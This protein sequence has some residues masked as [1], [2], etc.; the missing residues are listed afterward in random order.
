MGSWVRRKFDFAF[1]SFN[2]NA[3][4]GESLSGGSWG[5]SQRAS[6]PLNRPGTCQEETLPPVDSGTP[7]VCGVRG[8]PSA[9]STV[10][11]V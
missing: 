10:Q 2:G 3:G 1:C 4:E 6:M 9:M 5:W 7:D 8:P 11:G